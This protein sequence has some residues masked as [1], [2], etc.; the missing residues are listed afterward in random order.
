MSAAVALLILLFYQLVEMPWLLDQRLGYYYRGS[1]HVCH[2][3]S[4]LFYS[5]D[6][7]C[8]SERVRKRD[9]TRWQPH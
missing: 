3:S 9:M 8:F 7:E 1:P 4:E 5:V 2:V 6:S